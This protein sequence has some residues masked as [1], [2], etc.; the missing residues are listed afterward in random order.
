LIY[1]PDPAR[2]EP[3]RKIGWMCSRSKANTP[4]MPVAGDAR[5]FTPKNTGTGDVLRADS[6]GCKDLSGAAS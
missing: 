2:P 3:K 4:R 6:S 5:I 1:A